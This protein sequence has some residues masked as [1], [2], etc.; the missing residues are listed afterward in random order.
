MRHAAICLCLISAALAAGE[1][2]PGRTPVEVRTMA[3]NPRVSAR[4]I[5]LNQAVRVEFTTASRQ[6]ENVDVAAT[7]ANGV[8]LAAGSAWRLLGRPVVSETEKPRTLTVAFSVMPRNPGDLR[9]PQFP[10]SWLS[11]EPLGDLGA[12]TV[13]SSILVGGEPRELPREC[14]G[15]GSVDW[16]ASAT[17]LRAAGRM[18]EGELT[19]AGADQVLRTGKGLELVFRGGELAEARLQAPGQSLEQA[20]AGFLLRWG[21]PQESSA[22]AATWSLGWVRITAAGAPEGVRV[23]LIHEG[24]SGRMARSQV[25]TSIFD[26]LEGPARPAGPR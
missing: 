20:Q 3:L 8:A 26:L 24:V 21:L 18:P 7:V 16:G 4:Q 9:L 25:Q 23:T 5:H 22:T 10:L 19:A 1:T 2:P 11:G 6:I 14:A 12:V 15:V 13:G 17:E